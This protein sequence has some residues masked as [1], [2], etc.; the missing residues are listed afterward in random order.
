MI[1]EKLEAR[2]TRAI[3]RL[4]LL[5]DRYEAVIAPLEPRTQPQTD[6]SALKAAEK[7][8][9]TRRFEILRAA[10]VELGDEAYEEADDSQAH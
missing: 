8:I 4:E 5:A 9:R 1:D 3:H 6:A 2:M 7:M 10:G